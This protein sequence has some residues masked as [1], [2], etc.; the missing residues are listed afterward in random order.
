LSLSKLVSSLLEDGKTFLLLARD[1]SRK[2]HDSLALSYCRAVFFSAWSAL[3]GWINYI[4]KSFA[5]TDHSLSM[6]EIAFLK[7]KRL[8]VTEDGIV[9]LTNQDEYRSTLT[10]LVFILRKFGGDFDLKHSQPDLWRE[11]KEIEQMRHGIMHPKTRE[12]EIRL[13]IKDAE[14]C[15]NVTVKLVNLLRDRI[16]ER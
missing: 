7:E 2:G 9:R 11:L 12:Q 4:A 15:F 1:A 10:K 5:E 16:F 13:N 8:E 6:Y 14:K 3:E